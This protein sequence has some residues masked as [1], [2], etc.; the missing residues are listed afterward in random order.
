MN[1]LRG[2]VGALVLAS[3]VGLAACGKDPNLPAAG[4]MEPDRYLF[5]QGTQLLADK[6][7]ITAR[8][9]FK[10]LVD[11]YPGSPH[12]QDAKLGIGDTYLGES[13]VESLI[14]AVNE[15]KEFLQFFP[16]S[17]RADYAQSRICLASSKQM[18]APQRDQTAT[19]ETIAECNRFLQSY[20]RSQYRE[21]VVK[22]HREA[23]DRLSKWELDVGLQYYRMGVYEGA[24]ARLRT[25]LADDPE[26]SQRDVAYFH[27]GEM[28]YKTE[29]KAEALPYYERVVS[30]FPKSDYAEKAAERIKEIKR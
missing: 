8:E 1:V 24:A 10:R 15:Y 4:S 30:E 12:R 22:V 3:A 7:W 28:L 16:L 11:T 25:L 6:N 23:R 19:H 26:Y 2:L 13:R 27:L 14:L 21:E 20:P 29:R 9:Y 18:L 17:P 5:V